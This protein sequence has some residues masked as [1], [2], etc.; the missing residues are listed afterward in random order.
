MAYFK[1]FRGINAKSVGFIL[2]LKLNHTVKP[3]D[4]KRKAL[5]KVGNTHD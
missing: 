2:Q 1:I 3:K 5:H 4:V